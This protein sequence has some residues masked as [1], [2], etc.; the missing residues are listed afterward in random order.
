MKHKKN[1]VAIIGAGASGL[2]AAIVAKRAGAEVTI[3]EANERIGKKI[4]VTGNGKCN[5]SN[6]DMNTCWFHC[7]DHTFVEHILTTCSVKD[8]LEFFESIGIIVKAN[9]GSIYPVTESA[10]SVLDAFRYALDREK[11]IVISDFCVQDIKKTKED[12]FLIKGYS[13]PFDKVIISSGLLAGE[14][15]EQAKFGIL[16]AQGFG[17]TI[18][19]IL[20]ALVQLR[21]DG[22]YFS[23]IAGVRAKVEIELFIEQQSQGVEKG[24]L[25]ITAYGISGIPVMQLSSQVAKAIEKKK[26]ATIVVDFIPWLEEERI[27]QF[28]VQRKQQF[29]NCTLEKFFNGVVHKKLLLCVLKNLSLKAEEKSESFENTDLITI[30]F[31]LKKWIFRVQKTNSFS[32]AQVCSGGIL[33]NELTVDLESKFVKGLYFTGEIINV[34]GLCGGYNLQWAWSTGKIAGMQVAISEKEDG[35]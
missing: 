3:F 27:M 28:I 14:K 23:S 33:T 17:H 21:C 31:S 11:I 6:E 35:I 2:C 8:T 32:N 12:T 18:S 22:N 26:K 16:I 34:D 15:V 7:E 5:L 4:L 10:A 29:G 19:K 9:N 20:P 13:I 1:K 30:L 24:E 25:Q